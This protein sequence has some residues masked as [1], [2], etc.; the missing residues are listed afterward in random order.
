MSNPKEE[1]EK[2]YTRSSS[3][4]AVSSFTSAFFF[5]I[6]TAS[7]SVKRTKIVSTLGP[8]SRS[9]EVIEG[10]IRAGVNIFRLNF[11]HGKQA[12]HGKLIK[13]IHDIAQKLA[14]PVGILADLQG[15]KFRTGY[16]ENHKPV[17][18][19][20]GQTVLFVTSTK[21]ALGN[22]DCLSAGTEHADVCVRELNVGN[23]ILIN[24]GAVS[25]QVT[26]RISTDE[27]ECLVIIGGEVGEQKGVNTPEL[28]VSVAALTKKDASDAVFALNQ[29]VDMMALS[30]V[31]RPEDIIELRNL[32]LENLS[33]NGKD[34]KNKNDKKDEQKD[35]K[36]SY[37][38]SH[39]KKL[40]EIPKIIA[41]IE[42]TTSA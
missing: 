38:S 31:Q 16:L 34:D 13:D 2:K 40:K 30:F 9:P 42:K 26:K 27:L 5:G 23:R 22:K 10:L 20:K 8:A 29:G 15:P 25:L 3:F 18:L 37:H 28:K 6:G 39:N 1:K 33:K 35:K 19:T 32:L 11:S 4:S 14:V 21:C 17:M 12:D 7:D 36:D 41:K 24:D